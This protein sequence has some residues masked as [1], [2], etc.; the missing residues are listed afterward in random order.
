MLDRESKVLYE[1]FDGNI[2]RI[3]V[4][5]EVNSFLHVVYGSAGKVVFITI[6]VTSRAIQQRSVSNVGIVKIFFARLLDKIL[7]VKESQADDYIFVVV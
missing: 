1:V 5:Y 7:T 4:D 2:F 3:A 6:D